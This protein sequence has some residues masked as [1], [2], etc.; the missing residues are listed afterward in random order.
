[1][2]KYNQA[3]NIARADAANTPCNGGTLRL[4]NGTEP[5]TCATALSGNTLLSQHNLSATAWPGATGANGAATSNAISSAAASATGTPT[6]ARIYA[7]DGTT[8]VKQYSA[9]E[10]TVTPASLTSG[11]TVNVSAI[12]HAETTV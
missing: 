12:P 11:V 1:M 6:F 9:A 2:P 5:A 4:Y 10:M 7:S 8:C 3:V